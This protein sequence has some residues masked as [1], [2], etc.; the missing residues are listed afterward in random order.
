MKVIN[1]KA[2]SS[3]GEHYDVVFEIGE[4]IKVS[5]NC[6]AGVFGKLCKH[7]TGLLSGDRSFLYDLKEEPLLDGLMKLVKISTYS[8]FINKLISAEQAIVE[9]KR[10][11]KKVKHTLE[12]ALRDGIPLITK[13][14]KDLKNLNL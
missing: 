4:D 12:L 5:C 2:K 11:E 7:K 13:N 1:L 6:K 14:K 9:A 8:R 3:S 10:H